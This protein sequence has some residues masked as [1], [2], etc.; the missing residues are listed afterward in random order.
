MTCCYD[1][2][3]DPCGYPLDNTSGAYIHTLHGIIWDE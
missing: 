3:F 1:N 2:S